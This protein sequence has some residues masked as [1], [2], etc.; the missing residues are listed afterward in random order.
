[1]TTRRFAAF[2]VLEKLLDQVDAPPR[3]VALVTEVLVGWTGRIAK[4]AV[5]TTAHDR[6]GN[7]NFG[8]ASELFVNSGLHDYIQLYRRPGFRTPSGSNAALIRR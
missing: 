2:T 6:I 3:A 8:I 7:G 1:M 5:H 4:T